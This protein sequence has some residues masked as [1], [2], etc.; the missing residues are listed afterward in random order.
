M[1]I[2]Q[3]VIN[4]LNTFQNINVKY[5]TKAASSVFVQTPTRAKRIL[6][7]KHTEM[8]PASQTIVQ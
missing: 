1:L 8:Q 4:I 7:K 6:G 2:N 3:L 5:A